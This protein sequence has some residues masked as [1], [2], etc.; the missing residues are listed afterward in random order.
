MTSSVAGVKSIDVNEFQSM[1]RSANDTSN[2]SFFRAKW[3]NKDVMIKTLRLT[4]AQGRT[5]E[6]LY[7]PK[8]EDLDNFNYEIRMIAIFQK[9]SHIVKLHGTTQIHG[10]IGIVMEYMMQTLREFLA[11]KTQELTWLQKGELA[12]QTAHGVAD[13]HH[14]GACHGDLKSPNIFVDEE[15]NIK[16]GDCGYSFLES[17]QGG[18]LIQGQLK[19]YPVGSGLW[20]QPERL[21]NYSYP[22]DKACDVFSLGVI[23]SEIAMRSL[24]HRGAKE[25]SDIEK[26]YEEKKHDPLPDDCPE[27]YKELTEKARDFNPELRPTSLEIYEGLKSVCLEEV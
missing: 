26:K 23:M 18:S 7:N 16:I 3:E 4:K 9:C 25:L 10:T 12:G 8:K 5:S 22:Y 13:I 20:V 17:D 27:W 11:D 6:R 21:T 15:R 19:G 1:T 2:S 24:P 14:L